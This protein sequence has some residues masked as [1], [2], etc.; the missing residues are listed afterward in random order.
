MSKKIIPF[1]IKFLPALV[2]VLVGGAIAF[3]QEAGDHESTIFREDLLEQNT[4]SDITLTSEGVVAVDLDGYRWTYD[5]GHNRFV[6]SDDPNEASGVGIETGGDDLPDD[7]SIAQRAT[8]RKQVRSFARTVTVREDEFVEEDI[9]AFGRVT[10]KGWA[11]G[12][13][14]SLSKRVLITETGQVDGDVKAPSIIIKEGGTLLGEQIELEAPVVIR[15]IARPFTPDGLIATIVLTIA[16]I[17]L[18]FLAITL[19]PKQFENYCECQSCHGAMSFFVGFLLIFLWPL[20]MLLVAVTIVGLLVVPFIPLLYALAILMGMVGH[21]RQL[22]GWFCRRVIKK[23]SNLIVESILGIVLIMSLWIVT[24]VLFGSTVTAVLEYGT[25]II[26]TP[27]DGSASGLA[28]FSLVI[29]ILVSFYPVMSGIGA[30]A[31]T[32]F[33]FKSYRPWK[34]RRA[35]IAESSAPAPPPIP[36]APPLMVPG[37]PTSGLP[38]SPGQAESET[39]SEQGRSPEQENDTDT[40]GPS[41]PPLEENP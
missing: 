22:G 29:S 18:A 17:I 1:F 31:L 37:P 38:S 16:L 39:S 20:I 13:V 5:F 34:D 10:I 23:S 35:D 24:S 25:E 19:M 21:G 7:R 3:S 15:E 9:I 41:N 4:F 12:S 8:E 33:G 32:R 26:P 28:I 40:N 14:T 30:A 2:L 27:E 6:L 11:R 36:K